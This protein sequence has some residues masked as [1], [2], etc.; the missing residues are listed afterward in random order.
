MLDD[1]ERTKR[2]VEFK[3]SLETKI[4]ELDSQ[5]KQ[6]RGMLETVDAMLLE[7]G[8]KHP[9][10]P[11]VRSAEVHDSG[12]A[13]KESSE[14]A[15]P[16]A[17]LSVPAES[18]VV[19]STT[20]GEFLGDLFVSDGSLRVVPDK[21]K[22]FNVNTPPFRHFLVERVLTKMQ[23]RDSELVRNGELSPDRIFCYDIF[24]DGDIILEITVKNVDSERLRELKSSIR[25]T[26]EK[27]FEKMTGQG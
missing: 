8:F 6:N 22:S 15:Q 17:S 16:S 26:L 12:K 7:K 11:K 19:L 13:S 20:G 5:L 18:A 23:E 2:L 3:K 21:D 1:S 9:E 10:M 27:M 24:R 4:E 14:F 25:W